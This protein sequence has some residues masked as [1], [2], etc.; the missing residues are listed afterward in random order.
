VSLS[1]STTRPFDAP[2]FILTL[3]FRHPKRGHCFCPRVL[4]SLDPPFWPISG[5]L[6]LPVTV[7]LHWSHL[8]ETRTRNWF[9]IPFRRVTMPSVRIEVDFSFP[10]FPY[11]LVAILSCLHQQEPTRRGQLSENSPLSGYLSVSRLASLGMCTPQRPT[12]YH[13]SSFP[14]SGPF[15]IRRR[16]RVW[17]H[18]WRYARPE[19]GN[20]SRCSPVCHHT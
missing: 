9:H 15:L 13:R 2:E 1:P 4:Y 17:P 10:L 6:Q 5:T 16:C 8:P 20:W 19:L 18:H 12:L 14:F 7:V 11:Y 3:R